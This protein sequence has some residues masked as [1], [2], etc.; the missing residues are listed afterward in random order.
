VGREVVVSTLGNKR[1]TVIEVGDRGR[2]RVRVAELTMWCREE[3]LAEP[4]PS[5]K[6]KRPRD[7][8]PR[9]V[10]DSPRRVRR[11]DLHGMRVDEAIAK[12]VDEI[13]RALLADVERIEIVHGKGAG[14]IRDALHRH[15]ASMSV[16]A[17]Y[18]LDPRNPGVTWAYL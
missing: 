13:N 4:T 11:V 7:D 17:A 15:L 3:D 6:P 18:R 16:V 1:G 12:V 9:L 2:Y 8:K 5:K 10:D 14:R